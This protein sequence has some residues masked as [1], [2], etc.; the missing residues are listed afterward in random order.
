MGSEPKLKPCPFCG[1]DV[2][3]FYAGTGTYQIFSRNKDCMICF[4][5]GV[6]IHHGGIASGD[7]K[8]VI[9]SWNSRRP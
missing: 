3:I 9:D 4:D 8:N 1:S 5:D 6:F 2:D 7:I